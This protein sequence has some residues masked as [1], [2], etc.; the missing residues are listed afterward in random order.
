MNTRE[1]FLFALAFAMSSLCL[2]VGHLEAAAPPAP[3]HRTYIIPVSCSPDGVWSV[4]TKRFA[5][6]PTFNFFVAE[7]IVAGDD[8]LAPGHEQETI[9]VATY[10]MRTFGHA[11]N[12]HYTQDPAR[13]RYMPPA[14]VAPLGLNTFRGS[15]CVIVLVPHFVRWGALNDAAATASG[16]E[17]WWINPKELHK[18][19]EATDADTLAFYHRLTGFFGDRGLRFPG[20]AESYFGFLPVVPAAAAP[21]AAPPAAA[22]AAPVPAAPVPARGSM[23]WLQFFA[24]GHTHHPAHHPGSMLAPAGPA[25]TMATGAPILGHFTPM[26]PNQ[27]FVYRPH[28]AGGSM[29]PIEFTHGY[30]T[31][32]AKDEYTEFTELPDLRD[33]EQ[34]TAGPTAA[35]PVAMPAAAVTEVQ[36]LAHIVPVIFDLGYDKEESGKG[37]AAAAAATRARGWSALFMR[38]R[39]GEDQPWLTIDLQVSRAPDG[40]YSAAQKQRIFDHIRNTIGSGIFF[41]QY[42]PQAPNYQFIAGHEIGFDPSYIF[43]RIPEFVAGE[44][45]ADATPGYDVAWMDYGILSSSAKNDRIRRRHDNAPIAGSLRKVLQDALLKMN[46]IGENFFN[47]YKS[48]NE[49]DTLCPVCMGKYGIFEGG[50][51]SIEPVRA[52]PC[53]HHLCKVCK[54]FINKSSAKVCPLCKKPLQD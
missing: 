12:P 35:P 40:S 28:G 7:H 18:V 38:D 25:E 13:Y 11:T 36:R 39:V 4:L 17:Y 33:D 5:P 3:T 45:L 14:S 15:P 2:W 26:Q 1:K 20:A 41:P 23:E 50:D 16:R 49:A 19:V 48:F 30:A 9:D 44:E 42:N 10:L 47:S 24:K 52:G 22:P 8:F 51:S 43:V 46:V 53:G 27:G 32:R 54:E 6:E 34:D 31:D 37:A 21:T 29:Q